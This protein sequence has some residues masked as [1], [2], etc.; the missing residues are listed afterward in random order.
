MS[1]HTSEEHIKLHQD[2]TLK[3]FCHMMGKLQYERDLARRNLT[4]KGVDGLIEANKAWNRKCAR[5]EEERRRRKDETEEVISIYKET[6]S[7]L[8]TCIKGL[9]S[10]MEAAVKSGEWKVKGDWVPNI[11]IIRAQ[12]LINELAEIKP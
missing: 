7:E 8:K 12:K 1:K 2:L 9:V 6:N 5:L 4:Q 11:N 3:Q 10:V